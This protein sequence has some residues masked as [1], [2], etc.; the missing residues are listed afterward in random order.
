MGSL[1]VVGNSQ[2]LGCFA[3]H[4]LQ[5]P[6]L[7]DQEKAAAKTVLEEGRKT[8]SGTLSWLLV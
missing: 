5:F 8:A 3:A 4:E 6:S 1:K 7:I 2:S